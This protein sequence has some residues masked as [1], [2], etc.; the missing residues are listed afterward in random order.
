MIAAIAELSWQ[1]LCNQMTVSLSP[2]HATP[3][4][5]ENGGF[6]LKP[7][8]VLSVHTTPEKFENATITDHFEFEFKQSQTRKSQ[9][10]REVIAFKKPP[11]S[12]YFH[13]Y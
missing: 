10:Y 2:V 6:T 11:F 13:P 4:E 1:W 9:D 3:E 8:Q 12:K 7:H 5:L